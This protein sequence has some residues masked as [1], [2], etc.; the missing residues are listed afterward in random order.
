M[1]ILAENRARESDQDSRDDT[2]QC[3]TQDPYGSREWYKE[4]EE[5]ERE[6]GRHQ[7][8]HGLLRDGED[9]TGNILKN[10]TQK[11]DNDPDAKGETFGCQG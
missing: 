9:I 10:G 5:E 2:S 7:Q 1:G 4:R 6:D 8:V 3:S 11:D